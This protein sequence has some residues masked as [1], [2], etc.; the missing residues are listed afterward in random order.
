M[1]ALYFGI[2][3]VGVGTA[4]L[5]RYRGQLSTAVVQLAIWLGAIFV[6]LL[7]YSFR[8]EIGS[9]LHAEFVPT[10]LHQTETGEFAVRAGEDGHFYVDATINKVPV[11]FLVDTGASDIVLPVDL[12]ARLGFARDDLRFTQTVS[13]A[14]GITHGAPIRLANL[15]VGPK[16][17][18]DV[19]AYI[20]EGPLD[21]PLLGMS[22]LRILR[23]YRVANDRLFLTF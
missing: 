5:V 16:T 12:A 22:F 2:M 11:R 21:M 14:N 4:M 9:H 6:V 8:D 23:A 15:T 19:P 7:G 18:T 1:R 20:N 3:I 17:L 13:T 10:A